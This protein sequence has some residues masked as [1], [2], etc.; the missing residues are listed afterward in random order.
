MIMTA[1]VVIQTMSLERLTVPFI[2]PMI[3]VTSSAKKSV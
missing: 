3:D 2:M 1:K